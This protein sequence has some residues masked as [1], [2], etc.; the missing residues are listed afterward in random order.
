MLK[1]QFLR[2]VASYR[3][4]VIKKWKKVNENLFEITT[5]RQK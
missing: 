3:E 4:T 1:S 5:G 2:G